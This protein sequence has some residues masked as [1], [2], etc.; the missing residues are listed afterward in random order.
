[1]DLH[2][3]LKHAIDGNAMLF[4]GSGFSAGAT[5]LQGSKFLTGRE[6]ARRL[7]QDCGASPPDDDLYYAAQRYRK[8]LGDDS[9]VTLLQELFTAK[10]V[11]NCHRRFSEV[12]WQGIFTTNYDDVLETAFKVS[13]KKVVP[14]TIDKDTNSYTSRRNC[15]VH[16]NGYIDSLT[17]DAFDSSFKLTNTSYLTEEFSKS[18]WSFMFR[19]AL[20]TSR[21][22]IFI[23]YSMYDLDIGRILYSDQTLKDK[24]IFIERGG[25]DP[26]DIQNSIQNEFG[27]IFPLGLSGFWKAFDEAKATH[28]SDS[29]EPSLYYFTEFNA[30]DSTKAMRDDDVFDLLFKGTSKTEY[31]WNGATRNGADTYLIVRDLHDTVLKQIDAGERTV[32]VASDMANGKTIFI[33]GISCALKS[34]GYRVFNLNEGFDRPTEE[35]N[36]I[37]SYQGKVAIVVE[38]YTR[39]MEDVKYINLRRSGELVLLLVTKTVFQEVNREKLASTIGVDLVSEINL[40]KL[41]DNEI[42][43]FSSLL[44]TYKFWGENDAWPDWKKQRYI[45]EDCGRELSACLLGIVKSPDIASRFRVLFD[46]FTRNDD[47]S[48]ILITASV[49]KLLG[50]EGTRA[51]VCELLDTQYLF[52]LKFQR[53]VNASELLDLTN[54]RL[55]PRSSILAQYGLVT[56]TGTKFLIDHLVAIARRAHDLGRSARN[57]LFFNIYVSLVNYSVIQSMIP[58]KGKRDALIRFYEGTKSLA[59]AANHPHFWL[60]YALARLAF[61]KPEDLAKAKL[62]LDASYSHAKSRAG[63]HT[64]HLDNVLARYYLKVGSI[65]TDFVKAYELFCEAHKIVVQQARTEKTFAPY[66]VARGYG[67]FY[68]THKFKLSVPQLNFISQAA[69]DVLS[70]VAHLP[71]IIGEDVTIRACENELKALMQDVLRFTKPSA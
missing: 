66:K 4:T 8:K 47:L 46:A 7:Y 32:V 70:N 63:Y 43:E 55:A 54:G 49:L 23:G 42:Q 48:R 16:I 2:T 25:A 19:R 28:T 67:Q 12:R 21:A 18:N 5:P 65:E 34:R 53:N 69:A 11:D 50:Y 24:T 40:D 27:S 61:D 22:I 10:E 33:E 51:L 52:S 56:F 20:E 62:Y 57:E 17:R 44:S 29:H 37:A 26:E 71:S 15:C 39:R 36:T 13:G 3:A 38:N 45:R 9:L 58:E 64:R 35:I 6:L 59:S 30:P 68:N 31:I 60:Q 1:M 41:S 14:I